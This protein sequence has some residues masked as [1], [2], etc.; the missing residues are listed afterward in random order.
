MGFLGHCC[1][2]QES[3]VLAV[4][5]EVSLLPLDLVQMQVL[6]RAVRAG[7]TAPF[8]GAHAQFCQQERDQTV[9]G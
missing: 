9:L 5:V 8:C 6:Y 1:Y 7:T 4:P 2:L 3:Q